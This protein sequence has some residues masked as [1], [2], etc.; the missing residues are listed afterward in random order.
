MLV[1]ALAGALLLTDAGEQLVFA[2]NSAMVLK[3]GA[4][5]PWLLL[6][7]EVGDNFWGRPSPLDKLYGVVSSGSRYLLG[8]LLPVLRCTDSAKQRAAGKKGGR[9]CTPPKG[10]FR[11]TE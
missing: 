2:A 9:R 3:G 1:R 6:K 11:C 8:S 4:A 5:A 7:I 10:G